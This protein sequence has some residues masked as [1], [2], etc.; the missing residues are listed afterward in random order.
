MIVLNVAYPATE[1]V[2]RQDVADFVRDLEKH[3]GQ[4]LKGVFL[5]GS[6]AR[7][8]HDPESDVDIAIVLEDALNLRE[9]LRTIVDISYPYLVKHGVYIEGR[10][11]AASAWDDPDKHRNPSFVR[12]IRGD[13]VDLQVRP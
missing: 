4:N 12:A 13:A 7:G 1:D 2:V 8:D 9:E 10:P 3:Y 5:F 6:R 11:V